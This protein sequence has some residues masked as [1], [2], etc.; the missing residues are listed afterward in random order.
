MIKKALSIAMFLMTVLCVS[1]QMPELPQI[2]LDPAVKS[3][4]LDNGLTYYILH[5]EHPKD[6]ANFY[7]AQKVGSTLEA[8]TQLGLAHFLEHMAFNGTKNYPGKSMLNYLQSKGIR[9]GYDINA[10]TYFDETV[11]NIDNVI[12]TDKALMDSVLLCLRD[13]SCGIL[14]E[15]AEIDA[16]RGVIEEEWRMR[17]DAGFRMLESVLPVIY[18]EYQYQQSVI[19]KMDIIRNFPY[20]E[21]R[22]YYKKWYRPDQQGIVIVGDFD[23]AEMEKKVIDLFSTI[24]MPENA[25]PRTY[26]EVSDN[27]QPKFAYFDDPETS[28]PMVTLS[29]KYD[30][31][32]FEMRNTPL[33]LQQD[34]LQDLLSIMINKRLSEYSAKPECAYAYAGVSFG[35]FWIS[36]TKGAFDIRVIGKNEVT[37][38][39]SEAMGIVTRACKTGFTDSEL[40]RAREELL[41]MYEKQYN[42]RNNTNSGNIGEALCRHFIDNT[43]Y[44]GIENLYETVKQVVP[45]IPVQILNELGSQLLTPENQVIVVTQPRKDG[46]EVIVEKD[47]VGNLE[48]ILN[49]EYESYV[50]EVITDPLISK[51][52][53]PGKIK[54]EKPGEF[55]TVELVLSNGVKVVVKQT[56]FKADEIIMT[57]FSKGGLQ[58][59]PESMATEVLYAEDVCAASKV[60]NFNRMTLSKYLTGKNVGIDYSIGSVTN[61]V[62]GNSTVKDLKYLF[63]LLYAYFTQL[64]PDTETW[65]AIRQNV[66]TAL[67]ARESQPTYTFNQQVQKVLHGD[68]ALFNLPTVASFEK[69]NYPKTLEFV[70][71]TLSNA[72]DFTFIFTGNIDLNTLRPLLEQYIA[73]LPSNPKKLT[74]VSPVTS[75]QTV[76]GQV[77]KEWKEPMQAPATHIYNAYTGLNVPYSIENATKLNILGQLLSNKLLETLREEEGGTYSPS[78]YAYLSPMTKEW[79]IIYIFSTNAEMQ[80]KMITRANEE[81]LKLLNQGVDQEAFNKVKEATL[82]QYENK[83][84]TN[85]YW[86]YNLGRYLRGINDITNG[87]DAITN[88][89]LEQMNSFMKGLYDGKN[90]VEVIME[91][92]QK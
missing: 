54:S 41:A 67:T 17:N 85:S 78:A 25:A 81:L 75:L 86:D 79:N 89:T 88:L 73:T 31:I 26:P 50:D 77:K 76:T 20:S 12:T 30:K 56:D 28:Y 15:D 48:N 9:F 46:M 82:K 68:K 27:T 64:S 44:P 38:A 43:P 39:F 5:N 87:K 45:M 74:Q 71:G 90:R 51:L 65:D 42:E 58:A 6:R 3:G 35:D 22:D 21:I 11:Y 7:I 2:P 18:D 16:E 13:W 8:P 19:G 1:A 4:K 10:Y 72:A 91:G 55:N 69:V 49:A 80:D 52:P 40:S 66:I 92:V 29:F 83:I 57:A 24:Q 59:Y 62:S 14:L 47:F 63:E 33:Y 61:T 36:S 23:P 60:G 84:R 32:P 34:I 37:K 70:K 53:K